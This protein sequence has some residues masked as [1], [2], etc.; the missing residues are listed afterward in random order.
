VS[1]TARIATCATLVLAAA[2]P[3]AP[4]SASQNLGAAKAG[5]KACVTG[6]GRPIARMA[7]NTPEAKRANKKC[8]SRSSRRRSTVK[9]HIAP[10]LRGITLAD[11]ASTRSR[12]VARAA[13]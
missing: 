8:R 2:F 9:A 5:E 7:L 12:P 13:R 4:A 3:A 1:R 6:K 10:S 11:Q